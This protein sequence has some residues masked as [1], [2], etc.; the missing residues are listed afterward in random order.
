M[1]DSFV[2]LAQ[3]NQPVVL[4]NLDLVRRVV[5]VEGGLDLVFDPTDTVQVTG[6]GASELWERLKE[7]TVLTNGHRLPANMNLN[8]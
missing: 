2:L 5:V 8:P 7:R 6:P 3:K 4:L 1:S